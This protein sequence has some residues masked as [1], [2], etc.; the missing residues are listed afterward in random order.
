MEWHPRWVQEL[1]EQDPVF[2]RRLERV[3]PSALPMF[4][5]FGFKEEFRT[6][7]KTRDCA[8]LSRLVVRPDRRGQSISVPLVRAVCTAALALG[9]RQLLLD[10]IPSHRGVYRRYGFQDLDWD[11]SRDQ[12]LDQT[13]AGMHMDLS[14]GFRANPWV[15]GAHTAVERLQRTPTARAVEPNT[16]I[17]CV[18]NHRFCWRNALY[19]ELGKPVCPIRDAIG[20]AA[21]SMPP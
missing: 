20:T 9:R 2:R 21:S 19:R 6:R 11:L 3:A 13:A 10:C 14:E 17:L 1:A 4:L 5:C 16:M 12:H 7:W 8:E 15:A 18:C